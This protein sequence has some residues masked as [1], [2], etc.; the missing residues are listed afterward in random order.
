[1]HAEHSVTSHYLCMIIIY[2]GTHY[3]PSPALR[4]QCLTTLISHLCL[5]LYKNPPICPMPTDKPPIPIASCA[6]V[7]LLPTYNYSLCICTY[8]LLCMLI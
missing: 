5:N 2:D 7:V 3:F 4:S 8:S 1:M 6:Y